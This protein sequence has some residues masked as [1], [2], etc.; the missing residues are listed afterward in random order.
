MDVVQGPQRVSYTRSVRRVDVG[1]LGSPPRLSL[2]SRQGLLWNTA[3]FAEEKGL[4]RLS[5]LGVRSPCALVVVKN[6]RTSQVNHA[7]STS[8]NVRIRVRRVRI[9]DAVRGTTRVARAVA[10]WSILCGARV[11]RENLALSRRS[12]HRPRSDETLRSALVPGETQQSAHEPIHCQKGTRKSEA[13]ICEP[14]SKPATR[15]VDSSH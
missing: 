4:S 5:M 7:L 9:P 1:I 11:S 15:V 14:V 3:G 13:F 2:T 8:V 6:H 12:S 10:R